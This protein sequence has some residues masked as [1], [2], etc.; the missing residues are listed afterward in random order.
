MAS[1]ILADVDRVFTER[2]DIDTDADI[3][4]FWEDACRVSAAWV[5]SD[6]NLVVKKAGAKSAPL[7]DRDEMTRRLGP[8]TVVEDGGHHAADR[9]INHPIVQEHGGRAMH[10]GSIHG[11][12]GT[13]VLEWLAARH[14]DFGVKRGVV[15]AAASK[16][17]I[18]SVELD[19]DPRIIAERLLE[20]M[21]WTFIRLEGGTN[22]V[23]AQ[24]AIQ[25]QWEYRLFIVDGEVISGAG[26][27]EEF[28]PLDRKVGQAFDTRVRR[29]RGH[30][31]QGEPSPVENRPAIVNQLIE[32]G[33]GV[34]KQAGGTVVI[35]VALDADAVDL[36]NPLGT[37]VVIELNPLPNAG[38]FAS[39]PWAVAKALVQARDRGYQF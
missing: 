12:P 35:D 10:L 9:Y 7:W 13:C 28:T 36:G 6:E 19:S 21:D 2:L 22:D 11:A 18:W 37:P 26:C 23:F 39:D 25:L 15:K 17:G 5:A 8:V 3:E 33:R 31:H 32:F 30:L 1:D 29:V 14:R 16:N 38:L 24:D 20:E 27:V 34:A 4:D